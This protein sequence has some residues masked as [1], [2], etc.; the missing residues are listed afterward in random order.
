MRTE[1]V[2]EN[3]T[4]ASI[5][6]FRISGW[7]TPQELR[8]SAAKHNLPFVF[9]DIDGETAVR[10]Y[11][12]REFVCNK[13]S[14]EA[15]VAFEDDTCIIVGLAVLYRENNKIG[16]KQIAS[17]KFC[18]SSDS[19][20]A[21]I[22]SD[23][24]FSEAVIVY[25]NYLHRKME[26]YDHHAVRPMLSRYFINEIGALPLIP[27][28]TSSY[29]VPNSALD[30][31][32]NCI[33]GFV[34]ECFSRSR[35][36]VIHA[37]FQD[38]STVNDMKDSV[39]DSLSS[40]LNAISEELE[41]FES[42]PTLRAKTVANRIATLSKLEAQAKVYEQALSFKMTNLKKKLQAEKEG[43]AEMIEKI[44]AEKQK[45]NEKSKAAA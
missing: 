8:D 1:N 31:V 29:I 30:D 7:A 40:K 21:E 12:K 6:D 17:L 24:S 2:T 35:L 39:K 44:A 10:R 16:R 4:G 11:A 22:I 42:R 33:S 23:P 26:F 43:A 15:G 20:Q 28:K 19:L 34:G 9:K 37:D 5:T 25:K 38:E 13:E 36:Y 41:S 45:K 18:K 14:F 3:L 27:G 32:K